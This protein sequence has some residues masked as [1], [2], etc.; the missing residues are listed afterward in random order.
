[1]SEM[2]DVA[3]LIKV[4]MEG[5]Q[6]ITKA[7]VGSLKHLWALFCFI[8]RK[9]DDHEYKTVH[10]ESTMKNFLSKTEG[11]AKQ[12]AEFPDRYKGEILEKLSQRGV[13][14][15][16]LDDLNADD[17]KFQVL[18][19]EKDSGMIKDVLE[20]VNEKVTLDNNKKRE[21]LEEDL[22]NLKE[23]IDK[24]TEPKR[25]T[26]YEKTYKTKRGEYEK[27]KDKEVYGECS[28]EDYI[29]GASG[30]LPKDTKKVIEEINKEVPQHEIVKSEDILEKS[31]ESNNLETRELF[32]PFEEEPN[33][34]V[35]RTIVYEKENGEEVEVNRYEVYVEKEKIHSFEKDVKDNMDKV[36][37]LLLERG[38]DISNKVTLCENME[39][40]LAKQEV[41][42]ELKKNINLAQN[43]I[44]ENDI[45]EL[46]D[47][48]QS[49]AMEQKLKNGNIINLS[50]DQYVDRTKE[51]LVFQ[52]RDKNRY[53]VIA[54][55]ELVINKENENVIVNLKNDVEYKIVD[56]ESQEIEMAVGSEIFSNYFE[57]KTIEISEEIT[58]S[59]DGIEKIITEKTIG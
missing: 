25:K 49:F 30:D 4:E 35:K 16:L 22:K 20:Q 52:T 28:I 13:L 53:I 6:M 48:Y 8:K 56:S 18:Y 40:L 46:S 27:L 45:Q 33:I 34:Y 37:V 21:K 17:G 15:T 38:I 51:G 55:D 19:G 9:L 29:N 47:K 32:Y 23:K 50:V 7:T 2:S 31:Y 10:G 41:F 1:M 42:E 26:K 44:L 57:E 58:K 14:F 11:Q 59:I 12:I 24:E 43:T 36:S 5:I 54:E 39:S 3:Q